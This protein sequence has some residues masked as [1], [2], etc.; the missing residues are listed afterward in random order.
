MCPTCAAAT[1]GIGTWFVDTI[2]EDGLY[3]GQCP[4]GHDLLIGTQTLPHEMLFEIA[5][6]AIFDGYNREA[7]SSF[8]ASMERFFEFAIRV[9]A[10][11]HAVSLDAFDE[12]WKEVSRQSERQMG[13]YIFLYLLEFGIGPRLLTNKMTAL[14]NEVVHK[15]KLPTRKEA[16]A[17]GC[18]VHEVIQ[19]S[20]RRLR[21]THLDQVNAIL[22]QHVSKVAEKMGA[23]YP[24]T[25]QVT[26]T[27]LNVIDDIA[28]GYKPFDQIAAE[29]GITS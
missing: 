3:T 17:F 20:I 8:S 7:V 16:L 24:R 1:D 28:G 29:R 25:F 23:S 2:R 19:E 13:A 27:A 14:R 6:N 10:N 18:A 21:A 5:I 15:G 4:K 26:S 9:V 11:K 22:G 12:T